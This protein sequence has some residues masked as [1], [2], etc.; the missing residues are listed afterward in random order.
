[1]AQFIFNSKTTQPFL[2][3]TPGH[4][5]FRLFQVNVCCDSETSAPQSSVPL[6]DKGN[7]AEVGLQNGKL[8]LKIH[9]T[10]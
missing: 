8:Q 2:P 3:G 4:T 9:K 5:S 1:M 6:T 10:F 7:V